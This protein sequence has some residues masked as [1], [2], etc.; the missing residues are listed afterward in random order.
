MTEGTGIKKEAAS[1]HRRFLTLL[2]LSCSLAFVPLLLLGCLS[3]VG[4]ADSSSESIIWFV[5]LVSAADA[6]IL[7][8]LTVAAASLFMAGSAVSFWQYALW[9]ILLSTPNALLQVNP[10][11]S[12]I[13]AILPITPILS[14]YDQLLFPKPADADNHAAG[15][16]W[17]L[18]LTD[19]CIYVALYLIIAAVTY[20]AARTSPVR[21]AL[22]GLAAAAVLGVVLAVLLGRTLL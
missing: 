4:G 21:G 11:T 20:H 3:L 10:G 8:P 18:G 2:A 6:V 22:T 14:M 12:S 1:K 15:V 5:A 7:I 13:F 16:G 17:L 9:L 19:A